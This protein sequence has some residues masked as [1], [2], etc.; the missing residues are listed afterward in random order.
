MKHFTLFALLALVAVACQ[1]D[2]PTLPNVDAQLKKGGK[3]GPPT[4]V[5]YE[6]VYDLS[7]GGPLGSECWDV[8]GRQFHCQPASADS[9]PKFLL[10]VL[11][12][13]QPV[14]G[15]TVTFTRC[16][17]ED[18]DPH[19]LGYAACCCIRPGK[20]ANPHGPRGEY[21]IPVGPD[22]RCDASDALE[23][24]DI[25]QIVGGRWGYHADGRDKGQP[26]LHSSPTWQDFVPPQ[27]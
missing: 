16:E 17:T 11:A 19:P 2:G 23:G 26:D 4:D 18:G 24:W 12:D 9:D 3:P 27:Q 20:R 21:S 15:G 7:Q 25:N 22:G 5:Q 10:Q 1:Q 6:W 8:E 14:G 13:G